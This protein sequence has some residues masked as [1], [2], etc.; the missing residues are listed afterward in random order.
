MRRAIVL[1]ITAFVL[2]PPESAAIA[3]EPPRPA[4]VKPRIVVKMIPFGTRRKR[5][6]AAYSRR[7]YGRGTYVLA[8]PHVVVEH[9]TDGTSF[10]S[11]W[12]HFASNAIH[13]L[14]MTASAFGSAGV[15][16]VSFFAVF[17]RVG[18]AAS[19]YAA[20][21]TGTVVW[22]YGDLVGEW[23][24]PFLAALLASLVAYLA[25]SRIGAESEDVRVR[26]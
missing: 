18:G 23:T 12:N 5:Q 21:V 13:D 6:M 25:A 24:A 8:H 16:V 15:V 19:A 7:H 9:Y 17:T 20:L 10:D 3:L 2:V 26:T 14:V 1:L 4:D 22:A 11:A